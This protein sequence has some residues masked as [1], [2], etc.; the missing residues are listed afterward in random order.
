MIEKVK[1]T[2]RF[3]I[4]PFAKFIFYDFSKKRLNVARDKKPL[5]MGISA[6]VSMK[7]EEYTLPYCLESLV[8][9]ADQIIIIDNGSEDQSL[10]IAQNF[11]SENDT[12]VEVDIIEMPGALLGDCRQ[13]GL[14]A[15][16]YQWHLR[17][18]ADMIAHTDGEF[19]IKKLKK[20][21]LKDT[22]PRTLQLPRINIT[23]D[24]LHVTKNKERGEG[25]PILMWFNKD[26]CYQEFGK[27]DTVRVP[28]YYKQV[29]ETLNYYF[30]CEGLKSDTNLIHRFH[31]FAWREK[32]NQYND[33][34]RPEHIKTYEEFVSKRNKFL[35]DTSDISKIKFRYQ[36]QCVQSFE[37][38]NTSKFGDFPKV[39][40][41]EINKK[42][43]RFEIIYNDGE[44]YNR[45]DRMDHEMVNYIPDSSDV[46]WSI[47]DFFNKLLLE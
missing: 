2:L 10:R 40:R 8:G 44:I 31:Y 6:V 14:N 45:I 43:Q 11:K 27:F 36:R 19:D 22:T 42:E 34:N 28:K 3:L 37:K 39:L 7:N 20:K 38:L 4:R 21:A 26:I 25:E 12:Q 46:N 33:S 18:D 1:R 30:H 32:Y 23:G 29:K 41:K 47:D 9:F 17:W 13:A 15:T 24:F 35:F 5:K 16:R